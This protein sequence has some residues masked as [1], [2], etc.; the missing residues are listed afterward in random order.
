MHV[1]IVGNADGRNAHRG[2]LGG[3]PQYSQRPQHH[4][5][6]KN[7]HQECACHLNEQQLS[8]NVQNRHD[9][10]KVLKELLGN[11]WQEKFGPDLVSWYNDI[12][13]TLKHPI[14]RM[15]AGHWKEVKGLLHEHKVAQGGANSTPDHLDA[16]HLEEQQPHQ[17]SPGETPPVVQEKMDQ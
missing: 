10:Q 17:D 14:E 9:F 4:P 2:A 13:V 11:K 1:F 6:H 7:Q 3:R 16:T 5:T 15:Q 12:P 8:T